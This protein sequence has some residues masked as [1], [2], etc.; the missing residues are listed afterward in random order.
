MKAAIGKGGVSPVC[1]H[2]VTMMSFYVV[3][4]TSFFVQRGDSVQRPSIPLFAF[5]MEGQDEPLFSISLGLFTFVC[6]LTSAD[7]FAFCIKG[8]GILHF[9]LILLLLGT[10]HYFFKLFG[11]ENLW[12]LIL[13]FVLFV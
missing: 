4:M 5:R 2:I 7:F 9:L 3:I 11:L 13:F 10:L 12:T 8:Q 1:L 6:F